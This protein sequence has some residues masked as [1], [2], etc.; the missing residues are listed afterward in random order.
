MNVRPADPD[1]S[2][3]SASTERSKVTP[4]SLERGQLLE[5]WLDQHEL[6]S[7]ELSRMSKI[8]KMTLRLY[9][10]GELDIAN[11]HQR[12]VEKLLTAMHVSDAWAWDYFKIPESRRVFWRTFRKPPLGHGEEAPQ[13]LISFE[14]DAPMSGEGYA[15]PT[16]AWVTYSPHNKL[17]GPLL[18]RLPGRYVVA[19][20]DAVPGQAEVLGQYLATS[21]SEPSESR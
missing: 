5:Q 8:S 11:M 14:L 6:D 18:T 7:A 16:G 19:L 12:T 10:R 13:G 2:T 21:P 4:E 15:A 1:P 3:D 20:I 9:V 17:H